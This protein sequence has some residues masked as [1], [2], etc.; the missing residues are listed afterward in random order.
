MLSRYALDY[1]RHQVNF[2][3]DLR[4]ASR[5]YSSTTVTWRDR[6]GSWQNATGDVISHKPFWLADTR[7]SWKEKHFTGYVEASNILNARYF[8]FGGLIQP[9]IWVRGGITLNLEY[10]KKKSGT[11]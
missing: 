6:T 10:S 4:V 3:V 2:S 9:G 1:L 5:L 11:V 7:F 8:D